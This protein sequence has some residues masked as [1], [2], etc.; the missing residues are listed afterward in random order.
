[1]KRSAGSQP[2]LYRT[3]ISATFPRLMVKQRDGTWDAVM[4]GETRDAEVGKNGSLSFGKLGNYLFMRMKAP[5][6]VALGK[7]QTDSKLFMDLL[8]RG[9]YFSR[10]FGAERVRIT[11]LG[12]AKTEAVHV[13][14]YKRKWQV[15]R[16]VIEHSDEMIVT[17]SL[18]TP[19]GYVI[20]M[21]AA[22]VAASYMYEIDMK[23]LSDFA[24]VT[25]YGTLKR[26]KE[27]LENRDALPAAFES[28]Q[29]EVDYG[30]KFSYQSKRLTFSYDEDV[31]KIS[32]DSDLH[33]RF[34]YFKEDDRV[35][36]DVSSLLF[37]ESKDNST[38]VMFSSHPR[39]P[40]SLPD[41]DRR[42]WESVLKARMPYTGAAFFDK[43]RTVIAGAFTPPG[44]QGNPATQ[45]MLFSVAF[46]T[47]GSKESAMMEQKLQRLREGIRIPA[48]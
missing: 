32:E 6:D 36:W 21:N 3:N 38:F 20:M 34:S 15:R 19:G 23:T 12:P 42:S 35:V 29:I 14:Q 41:S 22:D 48:R 46:S 43:S 7:L 25:Y 27:F 1:L 16:W 31:M 47:E 18:P 40:E 10:S 17:Y 33:V 37:G 30:K 13:D 24:F 28:I 5:D 11:S 9:L 44:M 26:W 4:P 45:P 2:M 8:L 39:P